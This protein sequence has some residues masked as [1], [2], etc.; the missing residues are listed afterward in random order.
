[1][2]LPRCLMI[3]IGLGFLS[4]SMHGQAIFSPRSVATGSL[5]AGVIDVRG[6]TANP[7]GLI[8]MREWDLGVATSIATARSGQGFVFEGFQFG[9]KFL[10]QHAIAVQYTPGTSIDV[11]EPATV[12]VA[13]VNIPADRKISYAEPV[14]VA[15]AFRASDQWSFGVQARMRTETINDPQYKFQIK[16]TAIVP[17]PEEFTATSWY[18]DAGIRFAPTENVTVSALGRGLFRATH[19]A[20][21]QE[22]SAYTLPHDPSLSLSIAASPVR[23]LMVGMEGSTLRSGSYGMEWT[24]AWEL[25]IRGGLYASKG[26]SPFVYAAAVGAGWR[27]SIFDL[28]ACYLFFGDQS[29]RRGLIPPISSLVGGV[30]DIGM[31]ALTPDHLTIAVKAVLGRVRETLAKIEGVEMYGGIYPSAYESLAFHPIGKVHVRNISETPIQARATFF[32]DRYMD[33][34]TETQPVYIAPEGQA[35]IPLVAV[36]NEQV[37]TIPKMMIRDGT[38]SVSATVAEEADDKTQTRV[39]LHGK[40]DWDGDARSLRYFVTPNDPEVI[41]FSRDMLLRYRDSVSAGPKELSSFRNARVIVN[42]FAGKLAYVADPKQTAD[43]V[44]YPSETLKLRGGDC[45]DMTV[46]F[47]SL[48]SSVGISTAFVDVV[49]PGRPDDAHI[50]LLFDAGVEAKFATS[51]ASNP[52]RYVLRAN[53]E[54][55]STVWIPIETTVI[56]RGFDEAWTA[57]AQEYFDD[58]EVGLGLAKGWVRI[59]DVY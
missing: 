49:P 19:G 43:Y 7:A 21:P 57:G 42:A 12:T 45:A 37:R 23:R 44:Q 48:L 2:T 27:Y 39:L 18:A 30:K 6:F 53:K 16:D 41:R 59:V 20:L 14:A 50:F 1:M 24:P 38:V 31:N 56:T 5:G 9:R 10:E 15:Y 47:A 33:Q 26:E 46:C 17:V 35:D 4:T 52:K 13:G 8:G 32:V 51:V 55:L 58:A 54:G 34:P 11:D 40:N 28:D 3:G 36:F 25:S 22:F 29:S